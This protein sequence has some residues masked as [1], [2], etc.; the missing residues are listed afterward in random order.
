MVGRLVQEQ[1]VRL[2]KENLC[3]LY[4]H[5]PA[6]AEGLRRPLQLIVAEAQTHQSAFRKHLRGLAAHIAEMV[7]DLVHPDYE[8]LICLGLIVAPFGE[9]IRYVGQ[10]VLHCEYVGEGGHCLVYDAAAAVVLHYLGQV[11]YF[12]VAGHGNLAPGRGLKAADELEYGRFPGS[13]LPDKAYL[14]RLADVETDVVQQGEASV[15]DGK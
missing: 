15:G 8:L 13:V 2:G 12:Q 5:V 4:A 6:L 7:V 10:F 11:T 3:Q 1:H 14:V 9:L